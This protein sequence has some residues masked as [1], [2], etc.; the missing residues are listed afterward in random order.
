MRPHSRLARSLPWVRRRAENLI[1]AML[2]AMFAVFLFQIAARY[3]FNLPVGWTHEVSVILWIWSVLIGAAFVIRDDEEMRFDLFYAAARPGA[4]RVMVALSSGA[5]AVLLALALP[6]TWDYVTFM[7]VERTA[8]LR[9]R[10]DWL[11][12]VYLVFA[13]AMIARHLWRGWC[14]LAG[15]A[16]GDHDPTH[17]SS[18]L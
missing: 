7:K 12:A 11:Y 10:F 4:R 6:A 13:V 8:Y 5:A 18:G 9:I 16:P 3:L 1:A 17:K 2:A 15:R 14:A